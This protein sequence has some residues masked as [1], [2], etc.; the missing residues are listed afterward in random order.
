MFTYAPPVC[1]HTTRI[2]RP[3]EQ[4]PWSEMTRRPSFACEQ[5]DEHGESAPCADCL[6][7]Y[8]SRGSRLQPHDRLPP[9]MSFGR[10]W[11]S[12][13]ATHWFAATDATVFPSRDGNRLLAQAA[14]GAILDM[15][16]CRAPKT[17]MECTKCLR[18][19]EKAHPSAHVVPAARRE[20]QRLFR[21]LKAPYD[22]GR[23]KADRRFGTDFTDCPYTAL[24]YGATPRGVV[25]VVDVP[26]GDRRMSE[27]LWL[28]TNA[29]RFMIWGAFD[30]YLVREI[31]A[32]EL[33][34]EVRRKGIAS[35]TDED[36][37]AVLRSFIAR[38]VKL[39]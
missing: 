10:G 22:P 5:Y 3:R 2:I 11:F 16:L 24:R 32:K 30:P 37:S 36:K 9:R 35:L 29:K 8:H 25:L 7:R 26:K 31:P 17:D 34:A 23:V 33:R 38:L 15:T 21:G 28:V 1:E 27:E 39:R 19:I 12:G 14:C 4:L 13:G 6:E 18:A 20:V